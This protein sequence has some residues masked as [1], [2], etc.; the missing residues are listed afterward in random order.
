MANIKFIDL[1][2]IYNERML[3]DG[4]KIAR[5]GMRRGTIPQARRQI[6]NLAFEVRCA[7]RCL[8]A[9]AAVD[10]DDSEIHMALVSCY[11][12]SRE[13][14]AMEERLAFKHEEPKRGWQR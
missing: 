9:M 4:L 7:I 3:H 14:D 12:I 10:K 13:V 6:R 5:N 8:E 11:D 2:S 1:N